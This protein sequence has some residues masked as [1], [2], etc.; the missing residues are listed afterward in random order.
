MVND[1]INVNFGIASGGFDATLKGGEPRS[2]NQTL[3]NT[4]Q[5]HIMFIDYADAEYNSGMFTLMGGIIPFKNFLWNPSDL[6]WDTDLSWQGIGMKIDMGTLFTYAGALILDE[7]SANLTDPKLYVIQEGISLSSE[8]MSFKLAAAYYAFD[9]LKGYRLDWGSGTNTIN[10]NPKSLLAYDYDS[11]GL[12]IEIGLRML[13][14]LRLHYLE[15]VF[16]ALIQHKQ[17]CW[18]VLDL[19]MKNALTAAN[20]R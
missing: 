18:Q 12:G 3:E 10:A 19:E 13:Y 9:G 11:F 1:N 4:F 16:I 7:I 2:T 15:K 5:K 6:L 14:S 17:E 8:Q 20:G